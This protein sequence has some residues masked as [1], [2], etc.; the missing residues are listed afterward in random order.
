MEKGRG[1]ADLS[2]PCPE[3]HTESNNTLLCPGLK[4]KPNYDPKLLRMT[5]ALCQQDHTQALS[6]TARWC[7]PTDRP[8]SL[9]H[10]KPGEGGCMYRTLWENEN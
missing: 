10:G 4:H 1:G 9:L 8:P 5:R 2:Q 3:P 7:R 6:R